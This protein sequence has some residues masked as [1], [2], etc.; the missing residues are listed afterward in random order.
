MEDGD[1]GAQSRLNIAGDI[2]EK[3][4]DVA[5][6][7]DI[8][9]PEATTS[10]Y[11]K[12]KQRRLLSILGALCT[13]IVASV[14]IYTS[15]IPKAEVA[16][17]IRGNELL[18]GHAHSPAGELFGVAT[19]G[20]LLVLFFPESLGS[21]I[22]RI[23]WLLRSASGSWITNPSPVWLVRFTGWLILL[24]ILVIAFVAQFV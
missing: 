8:L 22:G 24:S 13:W 6:A 19:L 5:L 1:I 23:P 12:K 9:G 15:N 14:L 17:Y 10:E 3:T 7:E 20:L 18:S 4:G 21:Y 11:F 2:V 16:G